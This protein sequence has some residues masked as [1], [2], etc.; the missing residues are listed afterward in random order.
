[1]ST[2]AKASAKVPD[3]KL[4]ASNEL[5]KA[6]GRVPGRKSETRNPKPE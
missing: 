6:P 4:T 3:A 5:K 2:V 1:M